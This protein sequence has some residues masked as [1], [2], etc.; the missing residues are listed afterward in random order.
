MDIPKDG[1]R[2]SFQFQTE[3]KGKSHKKK[4]TG[5]AYRSGTGT[6]VALSMS[7]T[8][9]SAHW[10]MIPAR[11]KNLRWYFENGNEHERLMKGFDTFEGVSSLAVERL[12]LEVVL[13]RTCGE[14]GQG[15]KEWFLDRMFS[16]TSSQMHHLVASAAPILIRDT[17]LDSELRQDLA[18]ILKYTHEESVTA[19]P[20]TNHGTSSASENESPATTTPGS[21]V[22]TSSTP[23]SVASLS[24]ASSSTTSSVAPASSARASSAP[25]SLTPTDAALSP[26]PGPTAANLLPAE[27][28]KEEEEEEESESEQQKSEDQIQAEDWIERLLMAN[29][30]DGDDDF[31]EHLPNLTRSTLSWMYWLLSASTG[32]FKESSKPST[33]KKFQEWI[34][35]SRDERP[36][37]LMKKAKLVEIARSKGQRANIQNGKDD[38]IKK[39]ID[40]V[41]NENENEQE[42]NN[43]TTNIVSTTT[44][45]SSELAPLAAIFHFSFLR[46]QKQ[47]SERKAARI[48]HENE[49]KFLREFW[50][51][52]QNKQFN[53]PDAIEPMAVKVIYRPGLVCRKGDPNTFVKDSADGVVVFM[54][55]VSARFVFGCL[56]FVCQRKV[57]T[58]FLSFLERTKLYPLRSKV[59][60]RYSRLILQKKG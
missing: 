32:T 33:I 10:D 6:A 13:P 57:L 28:Q 20:T 53:L 47:T 44:E 59:V 50:E 18:G 34:E 56:L 21:S 41:R 27:E 48:G 30:D 52:T 17:D 19:P 55:S 43:D 7:T 16:G 54:N 60:F 4:I 25:A 15:T 46:P 36:F 31:K 49:K 11:N 35:K 22:P 38:L 58:Y 26:T 45:N 40:G 1:Y 5:L 9:N 39:I 51:L 23:A 29:T 2:D 37:F 14:A 12:L 8:N 24:A 3:W 42:I